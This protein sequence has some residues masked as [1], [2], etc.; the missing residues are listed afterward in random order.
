VG[1][2]LALAVATPAAHDPITTK[3]TFSREIRAILTTHCTVCHS[4]GG[5]APMA[6]TTYAETRPWARAIKE[7]VLTRRMPTWHAARGFGAFANDP[8]LTPFELSLI[9]AWVDGGLPQGSPGVRAALDAKAAKSAAGNVA[10]FVPARGDSA[11]LPSGTRWV[12]GWSFDPGDPLVT[13]ATIGSDAGAIGTWAAGD[14]PVRLPRDSGIRVSGRIRV[15]I[16]RR[17]PTDY[18]QP[19]KAKRSV[20]RL[21]TRATRTARRVWTEPVSCGAVRSGRPG[22]LLAVRPILAQGGSARMWIERLGAPKTVVGWFRDFDPRFTR[23]YWLARP[24][25]FPIDA[26]LLGDGPCAAEV[27]LASRP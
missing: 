17:A 16:R 22:D 26:R 15:D 8:S 11:T 5:P 9:V 20:F 7:Q 25:D 4:A 23:T 2:R 24:A 13:S 18:E 1:L 19:Y 27:T 3:V 12:T 10:V 14:E 21:T 6:L